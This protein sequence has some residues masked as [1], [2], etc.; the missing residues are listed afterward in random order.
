MKTSL[1]RLAQCAKLYM[2]SIALACAVTAG[3]ELAVRVSVTPPPS[4]VTLFRAELA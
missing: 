3:V 1:S 2:L 4:N